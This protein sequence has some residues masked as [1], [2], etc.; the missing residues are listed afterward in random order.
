MKTLLIALFITISG[1]TCQAQ[2]TTSLTV[3]VS[4][5]NL[6]DLVSINPTCKERGHVKDGTFM[7]TLLYCEPYI[8]DH[9]DT[10]WLVQPPCNTT[11]Y[12]CLRC[13]EI[14]WEQEKEVK[15]IIWTRPPVIYAIYC[16]TCDFY[17]NP[18][19]NISQ[20][21]K[22]WNEVVDSMFIVPD[23]A[24][25]RVYDYGGREYTIRSWYNPYKT[26]FIKK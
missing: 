26:N 10:T 7:S 16:D 5:K 22:E 24:T 1:I 4:P 12:E 15:K 18:P 19:I 8:I 6:T 13:G 11:S 20:F 9:R 3:L 25:V 21:E 23:D 14:I 17:F 2:D